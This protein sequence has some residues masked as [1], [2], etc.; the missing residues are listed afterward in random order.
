MDWE[1]HLKKIRSKKLK[2]T[3]IEIAAFEQKP[4]LR[5]QI[6]VQTPCSHSLLELEQRKS[7]R[8][9]TPSFVPLPVSA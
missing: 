1:N 6:L 4:L 3:V 8:K 9:T 5:K 7:C 2:K